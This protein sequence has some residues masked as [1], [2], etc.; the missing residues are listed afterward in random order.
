MLMTALQVNSRKDLFKI[1]EVA[2]TANQVYVYFVIALT[3]FLLEIDEIKS[4]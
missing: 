4:K 2:T 3:S 1:F